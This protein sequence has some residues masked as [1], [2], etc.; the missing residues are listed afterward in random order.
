MRSTRRKHGVRMTKL[1]RDVCFAAIMKTVPYSG[2]IM[3]AWESKG[4]MVLSG[5]SQITKFLKERSTTEEDRYE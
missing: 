1:N 4:Q 5:L 2:F 3:S